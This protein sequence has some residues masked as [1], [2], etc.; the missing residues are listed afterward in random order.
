MAFEETKAL[1]QPDSGQPLR[2]CSPS[3]GES[4]C[5]QKRKQVEFIPYER[6]V[7]STFGYQNI[8]A[9]EILRLLSFILSNCL[10]S[11]KLWFLEGEK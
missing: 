1:L 11:L 9:G 6:T 5:F 7:L 2:L 3:R 10:E 4:V 8:L